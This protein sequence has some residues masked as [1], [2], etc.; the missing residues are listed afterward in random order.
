[1]LALSSSAPSRALWFVCNS[2]HLTQ[3]EAALDDL[4]RAEEEARSASASSSASS[5][6]EREARDD[7]DGAAI[8]RARAHLR[9]EIGD[10]L[11]SASMLAHAASRDRGA[12]PAARA[13]RDAALKMRRRT[14]YMSWDDR[15]AAG[16]AGRSAITAEDAA[17]QWTRAKQAEQSP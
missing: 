7:D 13:W 11:F 16:A 14:P 1:M 2:T 6:I 3:V 15:G 17:A 5:S 9:E 10:V 8:A 4:R 12:G